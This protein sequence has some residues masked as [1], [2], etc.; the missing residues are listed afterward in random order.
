MAIAQ[1]ATNTAC[2]L[3]HTHSGVDQNGCTFFAASAMIVQW[4]HSHLYKDEVSS[5]VQI[6]Q[7]LVA[8]KLTLRH[9]SL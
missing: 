4:P 7:L 1:S 8:T 5:L 9:T 3:V 6:L 2:V